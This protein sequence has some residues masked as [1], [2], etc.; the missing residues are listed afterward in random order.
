[1][2]HAVSCS[3]VA[4]ICSEHLALWKVHERW[5]RWGS[6]MT[7][8]NVW[9][10]RLNPCHHCHLGNLMC[11]KSFW[12]ATWGK[13]FANIHSDYLC[14]SVVFSSE[15]SNH[16]HH[17]SHKFCGEPIAKTKTKHFPNW[18]SQVFQ[19]KSNNFHLTGGEKSLP[20]HALTTATSFTVTLVSHPWSLHV[21]LTNKCQ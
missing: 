6:V 19:L 8:I 7:K 4:N 18:L 21:Y 20:F 14:A 15:T 9:N 1:M 5:V 12:P 3:L 16:M 10:K 11:S 17:V 2:F 13:S